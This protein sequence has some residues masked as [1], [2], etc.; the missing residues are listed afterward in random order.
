MIAVPGRTGRVLVL[1]PAARKIL[2]LCEN[3]RSVAEIDVLIDR[4]NGPLVDVR[5]RIERLFL[6]GAVSL[7]EPADDL[8]RDRATS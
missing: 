1:D 7:S 3:A 8:T 5:E 2:D 6:L 4:E